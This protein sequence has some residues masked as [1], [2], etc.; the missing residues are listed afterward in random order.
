MTCLWSTLSISR[1]YVD[2]SES[3]SLSTS[4]DDLRTTYRVG[5]KYDVNMPTSQPKWVPS[6]HDPKA[7][8]VLG[9]RSKQQVWSDSKE[10][11]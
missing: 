9:R 8:S 7:N 6:D 4:P 5:N 2:Y 3:P 11:T 10:T 1:M